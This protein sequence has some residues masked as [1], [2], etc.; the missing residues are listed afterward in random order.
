MGQGQ[1]LRRAQPGTTFSH[2]CRKLWPTALKGSEYENASLKE[3][4]SILMASVSPR[5]YG[6]VRNIRVDVSGWAASLVILSRGLR[7][8]NQIQ[9]WKQPKIC[10]Q[11]L[12]ANWSLAPRVLCIRSPICT[13]KEDCVWLLMRVGACGRTIV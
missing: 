4:Q 11:E 6:R 1:S 3:L 8:F 9:E 2:P 7:G 12:P 13:T 10:L 5:R